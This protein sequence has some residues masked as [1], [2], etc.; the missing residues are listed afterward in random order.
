MLRCSARA[1]LCL[2]PF[3]QPRHH[4]NSQEHMRRVNAMTADFKRERASIR[5][6]L[7]DVA[8][9]IVANNLDS[10]VHLSASRTV[11]S[12]SLYA[13]ACHVRENAHARAQLGSCVV[14]GSSAIRRIWHQYGVRPTCVFVPDD[15]PVP[16]WCV[17]GPTPTIVVRADPLMINEKLLSSNQCDGFAAEFD[18]PAMPSLLDLTT[19][20]DAAP[21]TEIADA[22]KPVSF[23]RVVA[24]HKTRNASNTGNV[25]R[26]AVD[27]GYDA[28]IL[29]RCADVFNEKVLRAS[30]GAVFC[31]TFRTY[32][33]KEKGPADPIELLQHAA[34]AHRLL[35]ILAVPSPDA[36][37]VFSV[38]QRLHYHNK[39]KAEGSLE[40]LGAMVV[41][42]SEARGLEELQ[43]SWQ[44][45]AKLA[46]VNLDNALV[47]SINVAFA[48]SIMM[49]HFRPAAVAEFDDLFKRGVVPQDDVDDTLQQ[50]DER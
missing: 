6:V 26:A 4:Q 50:L 46:S 43:E 16:E 3:R 48:A 20:P 34:V 30:D 25:I 27:L 38:A 42:G 9:P 45:P 36:E 41:L 5:Q 39:D 10:V 40:R 18:L 13:N 1:A 8:E 44:I 23:S 28:V 32:Q 37:P 17:N 2:A 24:L 33:L 12:Q 47:E 49:H 19:S 22:P 31:P 11:T 35:P 14:G 29:D 21:E 15:V 7:V